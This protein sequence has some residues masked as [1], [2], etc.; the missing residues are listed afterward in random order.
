VYDQLKRF[1]QIIFDTLSVLLV[2]FYSYAAVVQPASTQYHRGI[3]VIITYV[4]V[5]L[6]YKSKSK[7]MRVV[8][9]ILILLS[10][11]CIG[12][13]I[14]NF[15]AINYRTGAEN[16]ID[17]TVAVVGVL[18]GIELARRV[19]G[20]A[21]VII[22]TVMILYGVYGP[23]APD[24]FAHPGDTFPNLCTTIYYMS[25]GVFGIMANVLAT[26]VILFVLFGAFLEKAAPRNFS[27][28]GPWPRWGTKSAVRPRCRSSLRSVRVHLRQRHRQHGL[29]R[30]PSPSHDEKGRFPA[31]HRRRHRTG[32][33]HRRHVHAPHHGRRR[34]H[35]GRTDRRALL[36]HHAGG[37][38]FRHS[39]IFSASSSWC[40]TRPRCTTSWVNDP[41]TA[42]WRS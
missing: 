9:Y 18:I 2:L 17:K 40:T 32:G 10:I 31:P 3:Y 35:H 39:C 7:L 1:E 28:T 15:E 38:C 8:D 21:F 4:L 33:L 19:V 22:G 26:Y 11:V 36:A 30:E 37:H 14:L 16:A 20:N 5:F 25:D 42:P 12:Y 29:H 24:L 27:S 41:S 13:W 6:L 23:Y 34:V